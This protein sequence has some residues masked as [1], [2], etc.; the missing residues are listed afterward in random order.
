MEEVAAAQLG[1]KPIDGSTNANSYPETDT[2]DLDDIDVS[3]EDPLDTDIG[4][5]IEQ[6]LRKL[7]KLVCSVRRS[8][9][10][11]TILH[12][13]SENLHL[14]DLNP[15]LDVKTR[16]NSCRDMI[17]RFLYL[18]RPLQYVVSEDPKLHT[19]WPSNSEI[20]LLSKFTKILK[21][22]KDASH[23][24]RL[25]NDS[26]IAWA[27]AVIDS[28]MEAVEEF[29]RV[30]WGDLVIQQALQLSWEALSTDYSSMQQSVYYICLFLNPH[31]KDTYIRKHWP[32]EVDMMY[33]W[34]HE[35][36]QEYKNLS[37]GDI[38]QTD[39]QILHINLSESSLNTMGSP[40]DTPLNPFRLAIDDTDSEDSTAENEEDELR[41][42]KMKPRI[43][44]QIWQ[45]RYQA[46]PLHWWAEV[47]QY[48]FPR[49]GAM[50]QDY[51]SP[52]GS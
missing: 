6:L 34:L 41:R 33:T 9:K 51:F 5:D 43:S 12:C 26:S 44:R 50:V 21:S 40:D 8:P 20:H 46:N 17:E 52:Q 23:L 18:R 48:E 45:S 27:F 10:R 36:W 19:L 22:Y 3:G 15:I 4:L 2:L 32:E 16:W 37:I 28:L 29:N 47:G 14:K 38:R 25:E 31:V 13:H 11:Q 42:Y 7:S 1:V 39:T 49:L 30:E 24:L 35:A